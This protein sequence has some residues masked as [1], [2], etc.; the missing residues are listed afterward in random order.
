MSVKDEKGGGGDEDCQGD[1]GNFQRAVW[2]CLMCCIT[3]GISFIRLLVTCL[4][5]SYYCIGSVAVKYVLWGFLLSLVLK[6]IK[7]KRFYYVMRDFVPISR[8]YC[9]SVSNAL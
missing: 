3:S 6:D 2:L 1:G 5:K 8:Q 4:Y 9:S 7:S